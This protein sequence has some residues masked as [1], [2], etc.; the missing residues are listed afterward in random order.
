MADSD[1]LALLRQEQ[2]AGAKVGAE[3]TSSKTV[4]MDTFKWVVGGL[5]GAIVIAVGW[6]LNGIQS[7]MRDVR[8]EVTGI[9]VEA[10][11]TNTK[12]EEL[13]AEFRRRNPR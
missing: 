12:L 10:A 7:D 3:A 13:I 1:L 6:F 11:V 5:L 4:P 9:R 8:K 2:A